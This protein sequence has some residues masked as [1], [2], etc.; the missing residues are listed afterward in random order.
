MICLYNPSNL[1]SSMLC[2]LVIQVITILAFFNV[3]WSTCIIYQKF[4]SN[5]IYDIQ[6]KNFVIQRRK[7]YYPKKKI[8]FQKRKYYDPKM[9]IL[10][11]KKEKFCHPKKEI[12]LSQK[13]NFAILKR[14]YWHPKKEISFFGNSIFQESHYLPI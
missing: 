12:L 10:L 14:K 3:V 11:S 8:L 2:D 1:F 7:L 4:L 13:G 9:E 5:E 6:K